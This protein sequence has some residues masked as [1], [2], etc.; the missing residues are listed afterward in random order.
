MIAIQRTVPAVNRFFYFFIFLLLNSINSSVAEEEEYVWYAGSATNNSYL[1]ADDACANYNM[2][3]AGY[4]SCIYQSSELWS[5]GS[6]A[7]GAKCLH[8]CGT[9]V[10][11]IINAGVKPM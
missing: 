3:Q 11:N 1:T 9:N 6:P 5:A 10:L 4:P 2:A 8:K 7:S